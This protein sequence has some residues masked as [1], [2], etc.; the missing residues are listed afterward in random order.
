MSNKKN[1]VHIQ[2]LQAAQSAFAIGDS[3]AAT[4]N[5]RSDAEINDATRAL[6]EAL[7]ALDIPEDTHA[8]LADTIKT[9][10][11]EANAEKPNKTTIRGLMKAIQGLI[12]T[13]ER[14]PALIAAYE[15]WARALHPISGS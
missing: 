12:S 10:V 14:S 9:V 13:F 5:Y 6:L 4:V 7:K 11:S 3:N 2:S 8:E 1:E 15:A